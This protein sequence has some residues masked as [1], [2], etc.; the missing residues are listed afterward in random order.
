MTRNISPKP[1]LG[2]SQPKP[3]KQPSKQPPKQSSKQLPEQ[4]SKQPPAPPVPPPTQLTLDEAVD[5]VV[6]FAADWVPRKIRLLLIRITRAG[7]GWHLT[8]F[9]YSIL[10]GIGGF[11]VHIRSEEEM[12]LFMTDTSEQVRTRLTRLGNTLRAAGQYLLA[13]DEAGIYL[14]YGTTLFF[15]CLC[16][17][18]NLFSG[19]AEMAAISAMSGLMFVGRCI[20]C[21]YRPMIGGLRQRY[22][23]QQFVD[24]GAMLVLL[25][26]YVR[27]YVQRSVASNLI[28]QSIMVAT[29]LVH[30][31]MF[32]SL[33]AFNGNQPG[34]LRI[35][36][37]V[38]GSISCLTLSAGFSLSIAQM[39]LST[40]HF[41][42]GLL[43]SVGLLML[44]IFSKLESIL[45]LGGIR[46][47]YSQ[48]WLWLFETL[49]MLML[50]TAAWQIGMST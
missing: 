39:S 6:D 38:L 13:I 37:L 3:P 2:Q 42:A 20:Q 41:V 16:A 7:F 28:L 18:G 21:G 36:S 24:S 30:L 12:D 44:F 25:P 35:L 34:L 29:L 10:R 45:N 8:L 19:G 31:V 26:V 17:L 11:F 5:N 14:R 50:L 46:L 49:A 32:F 40:H 48:F 33:I 1:P 22:L 27:E 9:I 43:R 4:S 47:R 23:A 15:L